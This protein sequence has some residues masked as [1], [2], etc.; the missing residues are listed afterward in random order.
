M[1]YAARLNLSE[2][3]RDL[4][5]SLLKSHLDSLPYTE[6]TFAVAFKLFDRLQN[7]KPINC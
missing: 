6:S 5:L 1:K 3:E 4:I 7:S 2:H